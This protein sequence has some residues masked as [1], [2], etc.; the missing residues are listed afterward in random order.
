MH[1]VDELA[2]VDLGTTH[3]RAV[4]Y[5]QTNPRQPCQKAETAARTGA[6]DGGAGRPEG[7]SLRRYQ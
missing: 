3:F 7:E 4:A 1:P 2:H 6:Q 5:G